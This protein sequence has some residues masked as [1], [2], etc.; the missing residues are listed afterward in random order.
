MI[1]RTLYTLL[2]VLV[3]YMGVRH[4]WAMV[5][6]KVEDPE[7]LDKWAWT[8]AQIRVFGII[9]IIGSLFILFPYTFL[10]G[11]V[12]LATTIFLIFWVQV[13]LGNLKGAL[14]ELPFLIMNLLLIYFQ[15][16]QFKQK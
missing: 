4:G 10:L 11:N 1:I 9:T 14:V 15:Y 16:P 12:V 8:N 3:V 5:S 7:I 6:R 2:M 13:S